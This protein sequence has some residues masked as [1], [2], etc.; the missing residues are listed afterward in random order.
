MLSQH[1]LNYYLNTCSLSNSFTGHALS[2]VVT[3]SVQAVLFTIE[4]SKKLLTYHQKFN[5]CIYFQSY[6]PCIHCQQQTTLKSLTNAY[7]VLA[8]NYYTQ[9]GKSNLLTWT[10]D[11]R[12]VAVWRLCKQRIVPMI[13]YACTSCAGWP[14]TQ[15][16]LPHCK[17]CLDFTLS[18][19]FCNCKNMQPWLLLP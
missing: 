12:N 2:I 8:I 15:S 4:P 14:A 16:F 6:F 13:Q 18:L 3:E 10:C 5:L 9:V 11:V 19:N 7:A 17:L 1:P